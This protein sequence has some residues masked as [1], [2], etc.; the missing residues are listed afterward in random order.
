[1]VAL[2]FSGFLCQLLLQRPLCGRA[3]VG[4]I[5]RLPRVGISKPAVWGTV[6]CSPDSRG[7]HRLHGFP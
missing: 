5:F 3:Q 4:M 2:K 1:M 7:L 6:V